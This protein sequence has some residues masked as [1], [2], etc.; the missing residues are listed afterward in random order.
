[1][2]LLDWSVKLWNLQQS[3]VQPLLQFGTSSYDYGTY[4][5]PLNTVI[6]IFYHSLF[7]YY[8]VIFIFIS[9]LL[10]PFLCSI[11][12]PCAPLFFCLA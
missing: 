2:F 12:F 5:H 1:M 3:E 4:V 6:I 7:L 10:S 9:F 11:S 8:A